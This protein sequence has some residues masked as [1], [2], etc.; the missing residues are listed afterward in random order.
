MACKNVPGVEGSGFS[1]GD[2]VVCIDNGGGADK[3]LEIGKRYIVEAVQKITDAFGVPKDEIRVEGC[4]ILWNQSRF[5]LAS[6]YEAKLEEARR[7]EKV[8]QQ[9]VFARDFGQP[10]H[11]PGIAGGMFIDRPQPPQL[12]AAQLQAKEAVETWKKIGVQIG[13]ART[14]NMITLGVAIG[15]IAAA[16]TTTFLYGAAGMVGSYLYYRW[17]VSKLGATILG[18][19]TR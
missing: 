10:L 18:P 16:N 7:R 9:S 8:L 1:V 12:T 2:S 3:W 19:R 15:G 4:V 11:P 6:V 13:R 14:V 5:E 17:V